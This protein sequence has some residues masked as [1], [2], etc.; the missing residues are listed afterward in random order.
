MKRWWSTTSRPTMA[1]T[2]RFAF[3]TWTLSRLRNSSSRLRLAWQPPTT[4][5]SSQRSTCVQLNS[6]RRRLL[7][8][9]P[10]LDRSSL[11]LFFQKKTWSQRTK[12]SR[13][14][15]LLLV[16]F[17]CWSWWC[18]PICRSRTWRTSSDTRKLSEHVPL[19]YQI[20]LNRKI[21]NDSHSSNCAL[22]L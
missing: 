15:W 7:I 17:Q 16:L 5:I 3:K 1:A 19:V 21:D 8:P 12:K 14:E 10:N 20:Y 2:T 4:Q 22:L 6:K 11:L 13:A 9:S 18:R